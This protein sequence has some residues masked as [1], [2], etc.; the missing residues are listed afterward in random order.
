MPRGRR[1]RR[2]RRQEGRGESPGGDSDDHV[3]S[4]DGDSSPSHSSPVHRHSS[5]GIGLGHEEYHDGHLDSIDDEGGGRKKKG[6]WRQIVDGVFY[7]NP[8]LWESTSY[9][10]FVAIFCMVSIS[11]QGGAADPVA[12]Q[13]TT[14]I[15]EI[16]KGFEE[17]GSLGEWWDFVEGDLL[18]G[19]Y[20]STW[21]ND[22]PISLRDRRTVNLEYL[23]L[24]A[25]GIRQLRVTNSSCAILPGLEEQVFDC[26]GEFSSET[27]FTEPFGPL[28]PGTDIHEY[29]YVTARE[30]GCTL[31]C[32]T[33]GSFGVSYP[34]GGYSLSLPSKD[35]LS[36]ADV[37]RVTIQQLKSNLWIDRSTRAVMVEFNVYNVPNDLAATVNL[38]LEMPAAGGVVPTTDILLMRIGHLYPEH[39]SVTILATEGVMLLMV[40]VYT[41][42][43]LSSWR[44][45]GTVPYFQD[46]WHWFDWINFVLFFA[47]FGLRYAAFINASSIIFPPAEDEFAFYAGAGNFVEL[48]KNVMGMNSFFTWF[49]IFKYFSHIPFMS[50]LVNVMGAAAEDCVAFMICF[51]VVFFGFVIAFFLSYGT[52][53]ENYSTISRCCYTLYLLTLGDFDFPELLKFNK[54]LGPIYF[55]M[56]SLLSLVLLLNMFVAIVMEGY[57][58]VKESEEKVSIV[59]FIRKSFGIKQVND[60]DGADDAGGEHHKDDHHRNKQHTPRQGTGGAHAKP[61]SVGRHRVAPTALAGATTVANNQGW[62]S[63]GTGAEMKPSEI[64]VDNRELISAML[65]MRAEMKNEIMKLSNRVKNLTDTRREKAPG[66]IE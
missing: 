31:G 41:G 18:R 33:T 6:I 51:F 12:F 3:H 29:R 22:E 23:L 40:L 25:V 57:D 39:I 38:I 1:G 46:L 27:E 14:N 37:S 50:R 4:H 53:V 42:I 64:V 9:L 55:I 21:Y 43:E 16:F 11:A 45:L 63:E 26:Y 49:K 56:F 5:R 61:A 59:E 30:R 7:D 54:L 60:S 15:R 35:D 17:I 58:V 62:M 2:H 13:L 52:Q 10:V 34:G 48:W 20:P 65:E 66:F 8:K 47:A 19:V 44:K 32:G 36:T 24:G 28:I